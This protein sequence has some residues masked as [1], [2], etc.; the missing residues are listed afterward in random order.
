[1][2]LP[3]PVL[4]ADDIKVIEEEIHNPSSLI[5][6]TWNKDPTKLTV[7]RAMASCSAQL[8]SGRWFG[9]N[10]AYALAQG[11][12]RFLHFYSLKVEEVQL[13]IFRSHLISLLCPRSYA[14]ADSSRH[15]F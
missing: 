6:N 13:N 1:M 2:V 5:S 4:S 15:L 3:E 9:R 14:T 11:P 7:L 8:N 12:V 10:I